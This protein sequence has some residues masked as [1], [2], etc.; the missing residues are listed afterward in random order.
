MYR[1]EKEVKKVGGPEMSMYVTQ[2][3]WTALK[4]LPRV[5]ALILDAWKSSR[6]L[7]W[8]EEGIW[9]AVYLQINI[10]VRASVS[11]LNIVKNEVRSLTHSRVVF[12]T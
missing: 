8:D 1:V 4:E 11:C 10:F 12:E 3:K 7:Q 5:E 2:Q 9:S 6:L